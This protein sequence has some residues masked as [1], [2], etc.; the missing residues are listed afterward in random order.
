MT[1][2]KAPRVF[3][4]VIRSDPDEDGAASCSSFKLTGPFEDNAIPDEAIRIRSR[5]FLR[6]FIVFDLFEFK[7][8]V[9]VAVPMCA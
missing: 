9:C 6:K 4:A 5:E 2:A 7:D 1:A 8:K 3:S